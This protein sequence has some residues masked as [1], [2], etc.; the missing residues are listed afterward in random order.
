MEAVK[1]MQPYR[2]PAREYVAWLQ[3]RLHILVNAGRED[4]RSLRNKC[5]KAYLGE[6]ML[7]PWDVEAAER[8]I[9]ED[10]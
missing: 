1:T 10:R 2:A 9:R 4:L 5:G 6:A 3:M 8:A 7:T